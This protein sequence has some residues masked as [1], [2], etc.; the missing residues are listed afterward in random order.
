MAID[1]QTV[2]RAAVDDLG[3]KPLWG[4]MSGTFWKRMD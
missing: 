1:E 3:L 2:K 4:S